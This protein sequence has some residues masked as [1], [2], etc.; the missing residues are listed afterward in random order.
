VG[1]C[2]DRRPNGPMA[3]R[4]PVRTSTVTKCS[5]DLPYV[6]DTEMDLGA[7]PDVVVY[8][9]KQPGVQEITRIFTGIVIG[10]CFQPSC[11]VQ[12]PRDG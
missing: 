11:L 9:G 5:R 3:R 8:R 12:Y 6:R 7:L 1:T 2:G 4:F 10:R